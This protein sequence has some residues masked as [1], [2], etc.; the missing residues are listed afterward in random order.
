MATR[1]T[2]RWVAG[3]RAEPP[4]ATGTSQAAGLS[5]GGKSL[6]G[7]TGDNGRKTHLLAA[8]EHTTGPVLAQMDVVEKTKEITR[9]QQ[10]PETVADLAGVGQVHR[11]PSRQQLVGPRPLAPW[12]LRPQSRYADLTCSPRWNASPAPHQGRR[13]RP[14]GDP[15][16]QGRSRPRT[17]C[18]LPTSPRTPSSREL[19]THLTM[20]TWRDPP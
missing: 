8:L 1:W 19:A 2:G 20:A 17:T 3:S 14:Q 7:A 12:Q 11:P 9:L 5:L 16:G 10:L 15:T 4:E 6:H 13:T 18:V